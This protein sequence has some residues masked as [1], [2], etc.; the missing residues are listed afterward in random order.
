MLDFPFIQLG[1]GTGSM[2][3]QVK[4]P[5]FRDALAILR[6]A[7]L[8]VG[9]DGALHHAAAAL[10]IPAIVIWT[11]FSS[12]EHL[13]YDDQIN[14]HDGSAPCGYYGGICSHCAEKAKNL[15]PSVVIDA[16]IKEFK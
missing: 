2:F 8:F 5:T 9:T 1:D 12:P 13:G 15:R 14:L 3:Q 16:I 10:S 7:A 4:T 11:G 6:N